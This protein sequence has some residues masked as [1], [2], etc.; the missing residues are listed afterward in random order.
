MY[1]IYILCIYVDMFKYVP[2]HAREV[3]PKVA[4]SVSRTDFHCIDKNW[5]TLEKKKENTHNEQ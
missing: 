3:S 4:R 5:I 1:M 2:V